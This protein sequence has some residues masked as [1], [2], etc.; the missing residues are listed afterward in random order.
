MTLWLKLT[1]VSYPL[2]PQDAGMIRDL[3]LLTFLNRTGLTLFP[4]VS[5]HPWK[6][7]SRQGHFKKKLQECQAHE[8]GS[9]SETRWQRPSS[10][11]FSGPPATSLALRNKFSMQL[12]AFYCKLF[13]QSNVCSNLHASFFQTFRYTYIVYVCLQA[14]SS[15]S[16]LKHL[17]Q[18]SNFKSY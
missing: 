4:T 7:P 14:P 16:Y 6:L 18:K 17:N 5:C 11:S 8:R 9:R 12:P 15:S 3:N 13:Q 10:L 1:F 2:L